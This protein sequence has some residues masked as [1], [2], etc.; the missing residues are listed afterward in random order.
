[1]SGVRIRVLGSLEVEVDGRP[2]ALG[3][4]RQRAL[5]ALLVMHANAVVSPDRLVDD[6]WGN[7]RRRA[8]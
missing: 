5:L 8:P 2:V 3:G 4:P 7:R 6:L 1:M